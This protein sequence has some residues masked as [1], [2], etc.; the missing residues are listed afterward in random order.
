MTSGE[1]TVRVITSQPTVGSKINRLTV[2]EVSPRRYVTQCDCK[3]FRSFKAGQ[4]RLFWKPDEPEVAHVKTCGRDCELTKEALRQRRRT[5]GAASKDPNTRH[6]FYLRLR[7]LIQR[8]TDVRSSSYPRYGGAG[9]TFHETWRNDYLQF[10]SDVEA[11]PDP[12]VEPH[13]YMTDAAA[14]E[15]AE[16][17]YRW[18][19]NAPSQGGRKAY[20]QDVVDWLSVAPPASSSTP[21]VDAASIE[22]PFW[23]KWSI[24]RILNR[25]EDGTVGGYH[26]GNVRLL[27]RSAQS[28]NREIVA[29]VSGIPLVARAKVQEIN[30]KTVSRRRAQGDKEPL[31]PLD[32][33][34]RPEA[35]AAINAAMT[36]GIFKVA[37]DG[38][39]TL[40]RDGIPS[41]KLPSFTGNAQYLCIDLPVALCREF[42]VDNAQVMMH[43]VVAIAHYGMPPSPIHMVDHIDGIKSRNCKENLRWVLPV[44]NAQN[45]TSEGVD[46]RET[47]KW[48][49]YYK[50][51]ESYQDLLIEHELSAFEPF[52]PPRMR[53]GVEF[54]EILE[55]ALLWP[56]RGWF[57]DEQQEEFLRHVLAAP[58]SQAE[59][60]TAG[61]SILVFDS[62]PNSRSRRVLLQNLGSTH[63]VRCCCPKC[64]YEMPVTREVR[65][66][67]ESRAS[68][69]AFSARCDWCDSVALA[70]SELASCFAEGESEGVSPFHVAGSA[71][72]TYLMYCRNRHASGVC[73]SPPH[74]VTPHGRS[75]PPCCDTCRSQIRALN[76]GGHVRRQSSAGRLMDKQ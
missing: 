6:W 54:D 43:R 75:E 7:G 19:S 76:L 66:H 13:W 30:P 69:G 48:I 50:N 18:W 34:A 26:P 27:P 8:C 1:I 40:I 12:A 35:D 25:Y 68:T 29:T 11:F 5:H 72:G 65:E 47:Q 59:I 23:K 73:K 15:E 17:F 33:R 70:K 41:P 4:L 57:K 45:R 36:R 52:E 64:E 55:H 22:N 58:G 3:R 44:E 24:D 49:K 61:V 20:G 63:R 10:L 16:A 21:A 37:E 2:T 38:R 74:W 28:L 56:A 46:P 42:K 14:L 51:L 32:I 67:F 9:V 71:H 60:E 39:I 62:S 31:R 53:N